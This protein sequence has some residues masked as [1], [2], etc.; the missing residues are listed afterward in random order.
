MQQLVFATHNDHK[1]FELKE[2]LSG[3]YDVVSLND[4][5][6]TE[7]IPEPGST[8]TEN[9][10]IKSNYVKKKFG[11]DCFADDTGLEVDALKGAPGVYSARYAGENATYDQN[12]EKLLNEMT[13][14]TDR[15]A[16]FKTVISLLIEGKEYFFEGVVEGKIIHQR[17]GKD[18]FGYDPVFVP[19]GY[20]ETFAEMS[21]DQK[22]Q[23]SHRG[24][25]VR[26][27]VSFLKEYK[28]R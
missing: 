19:Q 10:S 6:V 7:D 26:K 24:R 4:V 25:A 20:E 3:L 5:G 9:A 21:L 14:E 12:V 23:I 13:G 2:L 17:K 16:R 8:L 1:L 15:S 22:N 11:L 28:N 27:L 18:G